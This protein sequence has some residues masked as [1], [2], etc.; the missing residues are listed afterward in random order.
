MTE[1]QRKILLG[2]LGDPRSDM[3]IGFAEGQW[4]LATGEGDSYEALAV[5]EDWDQFLELVAEYSDYEDGE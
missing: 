2:T 5:H 3:R 4:I 1:A